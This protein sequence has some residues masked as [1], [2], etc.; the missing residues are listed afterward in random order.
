MGEIWI[1]SYFLVLFNYQDE[2]IRIP[3]SYPLSESICYAVQED[4]LEVVYKG[5]RPFEEVECNPR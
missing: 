4:L 1:L 3:Y 2:E 5:Y